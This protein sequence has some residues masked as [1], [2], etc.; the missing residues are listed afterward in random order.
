MW[1]AVYRHCSASQED[2]APDDA[3]RFLLLA[4]G[5]CLHAARTQRDRLPK[6]PLAL[7]VDLLYNLFDTEG[8]VKPFA[9]VAVA[10]PEAWS[11]V[12]GL[13]LCFTQSVASKVDASTTIVD[14]LTGEPGH[15]NRS[16]MDK[17]SVSMGEAS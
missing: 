6:S 12:T 8:L 3:C 13:V 16:G 11:N 2:L 9:F 7:R 5:W 14:H 10:P 4:V 1:P 17:V 15:F